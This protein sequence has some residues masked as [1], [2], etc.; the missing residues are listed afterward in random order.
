MKQFGILSL[1]IAFVFSACG[2]Q[3]SKPNNSIELGKPDNSIEFGDILE[4]YYQAVINET[5]CDG[6]QDISLAVFEKERETL[7]FRYNSCASETQYEVVGFHIMI[8][9]MA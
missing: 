4:P 5:E 1:A 2:E 9:L 7:N 8:G 6:G 3:T